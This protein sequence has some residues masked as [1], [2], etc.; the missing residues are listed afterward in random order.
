MAKDINWNSLNWTKDDDFITF[1]FGDFNSKSFG[2]VIDNNGKITTPA[3]YIIR[4]SDSDRYNIHLAPPMQDKTADVPGGDG[5]YYFGTTHKP[6]VF[7]ISFAFDNLTK[8]QI[9]N[10]K[11]AF[12]GK[13]MRELAFA[14]DCTYTT[15]GDVTTISDY[16]VYMAKV[17]SQPNIK[18][19][20]FVENGVEVYK[21]EGSV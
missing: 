1:A 15:T 13:E 9:Q 8:S 17:T 3:S 16:R 19:L 2:Q 12:N 18:A 6:K 4:T 5:Q 10:L 21:G 14:E 20:C 7:D 11:Q